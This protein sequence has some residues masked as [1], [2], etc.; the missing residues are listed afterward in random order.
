MVS[1]EGFYLTEEG[2]IDIEDGETLTVQTLEHSTYG[3]ITYIE[4][5]MN[6]ILE[7]K[8]VGWIRAEDFEGNLPDDWVD[9]VE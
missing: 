7:K 6:E 9:E 8:V 1:G 3:K 5:E 4:Y 2:Y